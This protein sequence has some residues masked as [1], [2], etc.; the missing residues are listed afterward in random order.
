MALCETL[1][2]G[3]TR[4]IHAFS[5]HERDDNLQKSALHNIGDN[6]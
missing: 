2:P 3:Y 4:K 1:P 6:L 5:T